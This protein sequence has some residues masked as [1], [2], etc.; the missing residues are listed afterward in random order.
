[1]KA[2]TITATPL[3]IP[4]G[5]P[6]I[7]R[8]RIGS[9]LTQTELADLAGIPREQVDLYERG[10]PVPLDSRRRMHKVLWGIKAKK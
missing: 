2:P 4:T 1:M 6:A 7:K 8:L 9:L 10:L 5:F 3:V